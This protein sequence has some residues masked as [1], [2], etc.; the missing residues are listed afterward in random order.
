MKSI[1]TKI[2]AKKY[3][4]DPNLVDVLILAIDIAKAKSIRT[5]QIIPFRQ[6]YS[7]II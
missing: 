7:Y 1:I 5:E 3:S 6:Y 2:I 4:F